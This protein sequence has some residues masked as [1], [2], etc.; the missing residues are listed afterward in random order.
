MNTKIESNKKMIGKTVTVLSAERPFTGIVNSV[1][2]EET[3][4]VK[5][6]KNGELVKA[7]IFD[8]RSV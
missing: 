6:I 3:V 8:I 7:S 4:L 1:I 5:S 2:D